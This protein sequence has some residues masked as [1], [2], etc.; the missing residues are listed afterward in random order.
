[1]ALFAA[2]FTEGRNVSDEAVLLEIVGEVGLDQEL[3]KQALS[4]ET[5]ASSVREKEAL[6]H[7]QG[8][9]GVPSMI[10]GGKYLVTGAQGAENY[11]K[12]LERTL[13]EAALS[14]LPRLR[15]CRARLQPGA[16]ADEECETRLKWPRPVRSPHNQVPGVLG[17]WRG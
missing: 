10:F 16:A 11:A 2:H 13:A 4:A 17:T 12:V 3:A 15:Q 9:T 5:F 14:A 1:M 7:S 6:W 8:I